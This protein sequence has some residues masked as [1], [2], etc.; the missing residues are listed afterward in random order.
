MGKIKV[1]N[2]WNCD[3][4]LCCHH[5]SVPVYIN[6]LILRRRKAGVGCH[7]GIVFCGVVG[8]AD[9]LLLMARSRSE[10]DTM[11][12]ICE[13]YV[14]ENNLEFSTDPNPKKKQDQMH[15]HVWPLEEGPACQPSA[16]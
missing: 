12:R 14:A 13:Q 2:L 1:Y 8:Y 10:T 6:D 11:L 16:L 9:D 7:M 3:K 15:L 5:L 4:G